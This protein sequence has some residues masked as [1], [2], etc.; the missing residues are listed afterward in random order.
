MIRL[1]TN[2]SLVS[3]LCLCEFRVSLAPCPSARVPGVPVSVYS[4]VPTCFNTVGWSALLVASSEWTSSG[5]SS[6]IGHVT[7]RMSSVTAKTLILSCGL[8]WQYF[9]YSFNMFMRALT[10]LT[11]PVADMRCK[12]QHIRIINKKQVIIIKQSYYKPSVN[13]DT[14]KVT[15]L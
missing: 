3:C 13:A 14:C 6:A 10:R 15:C 1:P 7:V 2:M 12:H 11:W 8:L 9:R 5:A 4:I